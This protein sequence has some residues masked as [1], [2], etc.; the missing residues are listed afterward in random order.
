MDVG[1]LSKRLF[2]SRDVRTR[3]I[4]EQ[5]ELYDKMESKDHQI[6]E[7]LELARDGGL[8]FEAG[9]LYTPMRIIPA[10]VA[11]VCIVLNVS[12][13]VTENYKFLTMDHDHVED[14]FNL[15]EILCARWG[16]ANR[17][18]AEKL[19]ACYELVAVA[20]LCIMMF[21]TILQMVYGGSEFCRWLATAR[22]FLADLPE[23][24]Y[25]SAMRLLMHLL[26]YVIVQESQAMLSDF[27]DRHSKGE[28]KRRM[29]LEA[30]VFVAIRLVVFI[31]GFD[32]FIVKFRAAAEWASVVRFTSF[33]KI[34]VFLNQTVGIV[35]IERITMQRVMLFIFAGEDSIMCGEESQLMQAY[36]A[37]LFEK[38][39]TYPSS[40]W[41]Q[42]LAVSLTFA[43][44][45]FQGLMLNE[46]HKPVR[47]AEF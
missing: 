7:T 31:F 16:V 44:R 5:A 13:L 19:V 20:Y 32:A 4:K 28:K 9:R 45:D 25:F 46:R 42:K 6:L 38:I 37:R 2:E 12:Q 47:E 40:R 41:P 3:I 26:P 30:L 11:C 33:I 17:L 23:L 35:Q 24:K 8:V 27:K 1:P 18:A 10:V 14:R 43:D 39:W 22:L 29:F 15:S 34:A 21:C 36:L